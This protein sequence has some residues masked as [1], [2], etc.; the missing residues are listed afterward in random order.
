MGT[1][2]FSIPDDVKDKFNE[3]FKDEN[4]SAVLTELMRR[5]VEERERTSQRSAAIAAARELRKSMP[6]IGQDEIRALRNELR[7]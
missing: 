7:K 5:A 6:A 2:N 4:K 1:M 3:V